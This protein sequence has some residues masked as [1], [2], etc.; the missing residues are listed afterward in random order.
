MPVKPK[1]TPEARRKAKV[2][3]V[4]LSHEALAALDAFALARGLS[5][6]AAVAWLALD[7]TGDT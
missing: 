7:A 2:I 1:Q 4:R 6:S 5:R 3:S